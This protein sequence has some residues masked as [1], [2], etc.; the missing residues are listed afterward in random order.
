MH[1]VVPTNDNWV[2]TTTSLRLPYRGREHA[3]ENLASGTG[4]RSQTGPE[5]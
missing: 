1:E 5:S 2:T 3:E 4:T